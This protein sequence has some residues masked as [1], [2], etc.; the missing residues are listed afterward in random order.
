[1]GKPWNCCGQCFRGCCG[2]IGVL[3]TVLPKGAGNLGRA[4][5]PPIPFPPINS[6]TIANPDSPYPIKG[7][8]T[9]RLITIT[10]R[11]QIAQN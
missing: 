10:D 7:G 5:V 4:P 11:L 6:I 9:M 2:E 8:D 3:W 1:M